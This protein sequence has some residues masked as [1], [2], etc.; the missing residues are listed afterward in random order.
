MQ[1]LLHSMIISGNVL[2]IED[3]KRI[4][5]LVDESSDDDLSRVVDGIVEGEI[6]I[7]EVGNQE[8]G[9]SDSGGS[10]IPVLND[11]DVEKRKLIN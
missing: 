1:D 3:N 6:A 7:E 5:N 10:A 2:G 4:E 8:E 9:E 11:V